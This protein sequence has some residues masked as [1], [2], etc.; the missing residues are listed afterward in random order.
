MSVIIQVLHHANDRPAAGDEDPVFLTSEQRASPHGVLT[1]FGGRTLRISLPRGSEL[2]DGDV[3]AR[4]G[5]V[6]VVVRA[7]A[8]PLFR[9]APD[10]ALHW[11]VAAFHLGNLHRPVRFTDTAMLTPADVR[12]ADVLRD[13]G[14]AFEPVNA[15]FVGRRFGAYSG[16]DHDHDHDLDYHGDHTHHRHTHEP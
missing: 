11:G 5:D 3:L 8:E 13:A 1:S 2:G 4:D 12:V 14:I 10:E 6:S 15:P 7:A 16:H 9:L